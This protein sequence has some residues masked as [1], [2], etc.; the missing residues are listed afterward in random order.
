MCL[1]IS[2]DSNKHS[3]SLVRSSMVDDQKFSK[4][5]L[6]ADT[7]RGEAGTKKS[8]CCVNSNVVSQQLLVHPHYSGP[9]KFDTNSKQFD[10]GCF[11]KFP[12]WWLGVEIYF[13]IKHTMNYSHY[14]HSWLQRFRLTL[15][16]FYLYCSFFDTQKFSSQWP[17]SNDS[18]TLSHNTQI[19][20]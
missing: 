16:F 3:H 1:Y 2:V 6:N 13:K 19:A 20:V 18:F 14:F 10:N 15:I 9:I 5:P 7:C 12:D 8:F 4:K 11:F 17:Q